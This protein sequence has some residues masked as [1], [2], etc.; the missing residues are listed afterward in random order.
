M[1]TEMRRHIKLRAQSLAYSKYL[2]QLTI[3][4]VFINICHY[5][6]LWTLPLDAPLLALAFLSWEDIRDLNPR[7]IF[8]NQNCSLLIPVVVKAVCGGEFYVSQKYLGHDA[9]LN[10]IAECVCGG[11]ARRDQHWKQ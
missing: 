7:S 1:Q 9:W 5:H 11:V 8:G 3:I 10:I 4:V 6:D 2:T